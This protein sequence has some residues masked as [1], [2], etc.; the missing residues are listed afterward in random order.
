MALVKNDWVWKRYDAALMRFPLLAI[1][2]I[3]GLDVGGRLG[4]N[5]DA[6]KLMNGID[7]GGWFGG[8]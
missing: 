4:G 5:Y 6:S 2:L 1:P 7:V 3:N 8:N